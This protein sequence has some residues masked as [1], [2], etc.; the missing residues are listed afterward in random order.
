MREGKAMNHRRN[1]HLLAVLPLL[2]GLGCSLPAPTYSYGI[3]LGEVELQLIDEAEGVH[4]SDAALRDPNNP[5]AADGI[6]DETRW[7][8]QDA[9]YWPASFYAWATA[10]ALRPNGENQLYTA[11]AAQQ[12]Y[13]R[14][15]A[16]TALL[17]Y[18][19]NVAIDGYQAILDDFPDDVTYDATG[20]IAYPVAPTAY[21]AIES[22]GATPIGWVKV[23]SP[24]GTVALVRAPGLQDDDTGG[25]E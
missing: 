10:L 24:D 23:E 11:L 17:Y 6:A 12:I 14:R 15:E 13:E 7:I 18:V 2:S 3:A 22:L 16:D 8:V 20:T 4:P 9:G 5:F 25:P 19:R 21:A 1:N